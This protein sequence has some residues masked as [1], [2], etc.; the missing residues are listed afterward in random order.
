MDLHTDPSRWRHIDAN[1]ALFAQSV[2]GK[3]AERHYGLLELTLKSD[4]LLIG[5]IYDVLWQLRLSLCSSVSRSII[6]YLR[7]ELSKPTESS[8]AATITATNR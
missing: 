6:A 4:Y 1:G 5:C 7:S 3:V 8:F 2:V